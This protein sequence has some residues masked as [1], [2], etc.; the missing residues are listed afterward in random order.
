MYVELDRTAYQAD[1]ANGFFQELYDWLDELSIG[2]FGEAFNGQGSVT[3][4]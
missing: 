1:K 2:R 3:R 4:A